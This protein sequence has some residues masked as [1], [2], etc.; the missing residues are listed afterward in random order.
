MYASLYSFKGERLDFKDQLNLGL[1]VGKEEQVFFNSKSDNFLELEKL[2]NFA[3]APIQDEEY[4]RNPKIVGTIQLYNKLN[5]DTTQNDLA[6]LFYIRK[7]VGSTIK[8]CEHI[9]IT[10]Q[11]L[12]G[13]N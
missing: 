11:T 3:I 5:G 2:Y 13:I 10:L 6:R 7:L 4:I 1:K 12:V 9:A 8:R